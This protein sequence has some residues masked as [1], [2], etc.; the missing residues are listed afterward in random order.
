MRAAVGLA[1]RSDYL[2]WVAEMARARQDLLSA[3]ANS[4]Q[5]TTEL[6][7]LIHHDSRQPLVTGEQ[8]IDDP[9][10][11]VASARTQRYLDTP[12]NGRYFRISS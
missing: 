6:A 12:A 5:A 8:G 7:R 2:R 4:R 11:W 9:L 3:E 10:N 1:E